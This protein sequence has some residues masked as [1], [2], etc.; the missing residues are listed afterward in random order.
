MSKFI[1]FIPLVLL[2]SLVVIETATGSHIP[3]AQSQRHLN[4]TETNLLLSILQQP[5]SVPTTSE[6]TNSFLDWQITPLPDQVVP[7]T[8]TPYGS[9]AIAQLP[10]PTPSGQVLSE[11]LPPFGTALYYAY[12][13]GGLA[14]YQKG[15]DIL[16]IFPDETIRG[17]NR[18]TGQE[19]TW[20]Q[21]TLAA[22]PITEPGAYEKYQS[23]Y[24]ARVVASTST[25][26]LMEFPSG[27]VLK[28]AR[29][30]TPVSTPDS[31]LPAILPGYGQQF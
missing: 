12:Q 21:A 28:V 5:P 6:S 26:H 30:I 8:I 1:S 31:N 11:I 23:Q 25:W 27:G 13:D 19:T 24:R 18:A 15:D 2:L 16:V 3:S 29:V 17:F 9:S 10:D 14:W 4:Q 20:L 22:L 7:K